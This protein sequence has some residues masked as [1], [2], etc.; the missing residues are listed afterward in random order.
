MSAN[1]AGL[2]L[3]FLSF[4]FFF[5]EKG[6]EARGV[7]LTPAQGTILLVL[8]G[9]CAVGAVLLFVWPLLRRV[10]SWLRRD[11]ALR[12]AERERDEYQKTLKTLERGLQE[13]GVKIT[14]DMDKQ[15]ARTKQLTDELRNG[16][17]E[18]ELRETKKQ[19]DSLQEQIAKLQN[20]VAPLLLSELK[21]LCI[22]LAEELE[23]EDTVYKDGEHAIQIWIP[24]LKAQGLSESEIDEK[25]DDARYNNAKRAINRYNKRHKDRLLNLYDALGSREWFSPSDRRGFANLKDPYHFRNVARRL[26]EVCDKWP[27]S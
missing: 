1:K 23:W 6:L 21:P 20:Q 18:E 19:R 4:G 5:A 8:A 15:I 24:D 17:L 22:H 7:V 10:W 26:R 2:A 16:R 11:E 3:T 13:L 25:L 12:E 14:G 9:L 27:D